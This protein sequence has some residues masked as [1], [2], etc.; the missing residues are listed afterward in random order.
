MHKTSWCSNFSLC[1]G[2]IPTSLF[3]LPALQ[4]LDLSHNNLSGP[5]H[6][7]DGVSS[8]LKIVFLYMN[9]LTGKIPQSLLV[10]PNLTHL[11]IHGNNLM[12]SVDLAASLWRLKDLTY[13]Q[14]SDNKLTVTEGKGSNSSSTYPSRLFLLGLASCNM[15]KIPKLLMR[16]NH[17]AYLN[18]S[19]N[20]IS[21]DIPNW[22]WEIQN[23]EPRTLDLSH[24][25]FTGVE[26]NSYV[27]P[28][29]SVLNV[30]DLSSNRLQGQ[31][32]MPSSSALSLDY[33]NNMFSSLLPNFSLYLGSTNYLKL[34]N[35][36]I[37]SDLSHSICNSP[38]E[39][40]D[41]SYNKF[42]GTV[43]PCLIG[44]GLSILNLGENQFEGMLP[45][46]VSSGCSVETID[47][48]GN[49]IEGQ[50]PRALHNCT[51]L[52]VL[53]LGRNQIADTFPYWLGTLL[54]LR[55]LVLRSNQF[56]GSIGYLKDEKSRQHFSSLQIIDLASNKFS[57]N[58]HP[59][60]FQNLKAMKKC[61]N[62]GQIIGHQ[63]LTTIGFYQ[64]SV[65]ISYKGSA[66]TF[67]RILTTLTAI[68]I[69][70][71][72]LEGTIPVS[73]GNLVSLHVLNMSH[74]AFS[75]E[76]PP[77]LGSMTSLES[78]DLSSNMLSGE[79]PQELT[80]LTFLSV[81]NLSNNQLHGRIPQSR[82]FET[83]Q[84]SSFDGNVGLCGP[85]LSKLCGTPDPKQRKSEKLL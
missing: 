19:S 72:A 60:W 85:P 30:F 53:D 70:D 24:N 82:Q 77:Q 59:Q 66:M 13:L 62:K 76:I 49:K 81:L 84:D 55:V 40:L 4:H 71:N 52:E 27:I 47:L 50:L 31:I 38:L 34:S 1:A 41:L 12:G 63:N 14:L 22:I 2:Q 67:E 20:K 48:H 57:G 10:L 69:S 75:G 68:D 17:M 7:L 8:C 54:N 11:D 26:L 78:L 21:G 39:I 74:N 58:L 3:T 23:Y 83:F 42:S 44:N 32:P 64:D 35:N 6:E 37:T 33:S 46:N 65:T 25:L 15:K 61:N 16:L 73:V 29:S 79:I 56:H 45:S 28:F 36:N 5:I 18:L 51:N 43:P 80:N 9:E